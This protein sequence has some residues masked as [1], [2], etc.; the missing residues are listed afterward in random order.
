MKLIGIAIVVL[1]TIFG[2]VGGASA[3][4]AGT[5]QS[6]V[7]PQQKVAKSIK[8]SPPPEQVPPC[9]ANGTCT[10]A[11]PEQGRVL[12]ASAAPKQTMPR[13]CLHWRTKEFLDDRYW[14]YYA[15]EAVRKKSMLCDTQS[16]AILEL[17]KNWAAFE[18]P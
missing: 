17:R 3:Q 14:Q 13:Q 6:R 18:M 2:L 10:C 5:E 15:D 4:L 7:A 12:R 8:P 9:C 11:L 1:V 16:F